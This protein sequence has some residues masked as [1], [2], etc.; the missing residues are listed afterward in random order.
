MRDSFISL[1]IFAKHPAWC[2]K[3]FHHAHFSLLV[4]V[5]GCQPAKCC[6]ASSCGPA[7]DD[8]GQGG[9]SQTHAQP[10]QAQ[11][12]EDTTVASHTALLDDEDDVTV[13]KKARLYSL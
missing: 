6:N 9:H 3:S 8:E 10:S 2:F 4:A 7:T 5:D 13:Q 12:R 1:D 11:P